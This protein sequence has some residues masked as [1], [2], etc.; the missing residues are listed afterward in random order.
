MKVEELGKQFAE[1]RQVG[2]AAEDL[3]NTVLQIHSMSTKTTLYF[4]NKMQDG[5]FVMNTKLEALG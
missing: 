3:A 2:A 5:T 1:L 4:E